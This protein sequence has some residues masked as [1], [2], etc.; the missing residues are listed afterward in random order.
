MSKKTQHF[1]NNI[2]VKGIV[3]N[4]SLGTAGYVLA[5]N[6]TSTYWAGGAGSGINAD[7]LDGYDS[8]AFALL[9][10]AN[11]TG[12]LSVSGNVVWHAGN[13]GAGSGLD[14]DLL[15][16]YNTTLIGAA[17]SIPVINSNGEIKWGAGVGSYNGGNPRNV[18]IGYSGGNYGALGYG[19]TFTSTSDLHNYGLNDVPTLIELYSGINVKSATSGTI[20]SPITW[21]DVFRARAVD[22]NALFKN[23][24][25]WDSGNDGSGSGLDADTLDGYDTTLTGGGSR[26]PVLLTG[27]GAWINNIGYNPEAD[28]YTGDGVVSPNYGMIA[29]NYTSF[30]GLGLGL[31]GYSG[32]KFATLGIERMRIDS[33]GDVGIGT[34][35]PTEKLQVEINTGING[36]EKGIALTNAS[37]SNLF[38][39][40]TGTGT[41]DKRALI[42]TGTATPLTFGTSYSEKMR[43]LNNGNFGIGAVPDSMLHVAGPNT[44]LRIGFGG[45]SQNYYDADNHYFRTGAA[46]TSMTINNSGSVAAVADFRAPIFYDSD[47]TSFYL[48]PNGSTSLNAAGNLLAA[49]NLVLGNGVDRYVRI[50]SSTNYLY[51]LKS[52][53]DDFQI[54]EAGTTP[55]FTIRYP[56][57]NVGIGTVVPSDKLVVSSNSGTVRSVIEQLDATGGTLAEFKATHGSGAS[58]RFTVGAGFAAFGLISSG[59]LVFLTGDVERA[60]FNSDGNF[61][62]NSNTVELGA[63]FRNLVIEDT[64]GAIVQTQ[65]GSG[66]VKAAMYAAG[67]AGYFG[68]RTNHST[69]FIVNNNVKATL[70]NAGY[71][72]IN[73]TSPQKYLHVT[74][75]DQ[76]ESRIRIQNT[77]I[78]GRA[79]DIVAG[80]HNTYQSGFSITDVTANLAR[81]V[82]DNNGNVGIGALAP[83]AALDIVGASSDTL[84]LRNGA[85]ANFYRIGRNTVTGELDFYGNQSGAYGYIFG[86]VDGE[87]MRIATNGNVAIGSPTPRGNLT[88]GT[89]AAGSVIE[90]SLHFGYTPAN[91]YGFR[92]VNQSNA[93]AT[94]AGLF[95][96]QRGTTA[97]WIDAVTISDQGDVGIGTSP[98]VKLHVESGAISEVVRLNSTGDTYIGLYNSGTIGAYLQSAA[99]AMYIWNSRNTPLLFGTNN[100]ERVRIAADGTFTHNGS[101][102]WDAGNDGSGSGLDADLLDGIQAVGLF[103]NMGANHGAF[104]DFNATPNFGSFFIQGTANGPATGSSQHYGI[105]LGIGADY[106]HSDYALQMAIGRYSDI[107]GPTTA[108]GARYLSVR[109]R[110][111]TTW[112]PWYKI[113]SGLSDKVGYTHPAQG[114]GG[115]NYVGY[116]PEG[117]SY[118]SGSASN[119]GAIR[120]L[121]PGGDATHKNAMISFTV[122]VYQYATGL[123]F[124]LHLAGYTY[125]AGARWLNCSASLVGDPSNNAEHTVRFGYDEASSRFCVYIGDVGTSWAYARIQVLDVGVNYTQEQSRLWIDG[126]NIDYVT[127]FSTV[128]VTKTN[129]TVG[130]YFN[131]QLI[132]NAGNDGSGSGL[133]AD[134]LDGY[135]LSLSQ[136]VNTVVARDGSGYVYLNY[137]N[138]NTANSENPSIGNIITTNGGDGFYRKSSP[139]HVISQ[140]A[141]VTD[142]NGSNITGPKYFI[143]NYNTGAGASPPLQA[144][145]NDNAQGAVMAFHRSGLYAVNMG[146]DS[147]NI[148]RIGGW[149]A[150]ANV[151]QLTMAGNAQFL[152]KV[153]ASGLGGFSATTFAVNSRNPIYRFDNADAF[154]LSYFQGTTS[155]IGTDTVGIHFGTATDAGCFFAVRNGSHTYSAGSFRSPIFYDSDNTAWFIDAAGTSQ[156]NILTLGGRG[157]DQ[158]VYYAGFTLDANTMPGNSTGFSY[159][160]NSPFTGP[161]ARFGEVNYSMQMA[162]PYGAPGNGLAFRSRNGDTGTF[163]S[164]FN[165]ALYDSTANASA[166]YATIYYDVNNTAY[167]TDPASTSVMNVIQFA[168]YGAQ[169]AANDQ[170]TYT[171]HKLVG[172][173]GGYYGFHLQGVTGAF[174]PVMWDAAGNGGSYVESS[175]LWTQYYSKANLCWGF[176]TSATNA[177]FDI[178]LPEGLYSGGRVDGSIFYDSNDTGYYCDPNGTS[179]LNVTKAYYHRR[180]THETGHLE[181]GYNNIG[182]SD[183]YTNPI[184]TIGSSYNPA[185]TTLSNMYGI[186]YSEATAASFNPSGATTW[187]MYVAAAGVCGIWLDGSGNIW[188]T[189]NITAYASDRRLKTNIKP[190][191]NA[192]D[193]LMRI[194]GV[195]FDWVDNIEEIGFKP[196]NMH[197]TGVIAQEIQEVIPDAVVLA[198]FNNHATELVGY[199]SEYLTVDKEKIIPLLIE[200]IKEQQLHI[201][202]LEEKIN[203][204]GINT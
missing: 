112:N 150:P 176:N 156:L 61:L 123:S 2:S 104:G 3:A 159:A 90:S 200:A 24:Q 166:L 14:A 48:D 172:A 41:S 127:S 109:N 92:I 78:T 93:S 152:G 165:V 148:F 5:S 179:N 88:I 56:S 27:G 16:G 58:G 173:K 146:L 42:A 20:G 32:M 157:T 45:A 30:G 133:D 13:D 142:S 175:G 197:E 97:A 199:D 158:A 102:I 110:E 98:A 36:F 72:G 134:L 113:A 107:E 12:S 55:R 115:Q 196:L 1:F 171:A 118:Y 50:G 40:V 6:G 122:R 137:I 106:P 151:M 170:T 103:N 139:A 178:Y 63:G 192:I 62:I 108:S 128:A 181:G 91:F 28:T 10:G 186:G 120:V 84:R 71:F 132:W 25:I 26:I 116:G 164:W 4:S 18:A 160:V 21:T 59:P 114:G 39:Y 35:N 162:M 145:S 167:Y 141:L 11:F 8:S 101:L 73:E 7:F 174:H 34:I 143:S 54:L 86:G 105:A 69:L 153:T 129:I 163:N 89:Q 15:D 77:G 161:I 64:S 80:V 99:G 95:K 100:T 195:E 76:T 60:R 131:N 126:W 111:A 53:G 147:D 38:L 65:T 29:G 43:L 82:I 144:Y 96:I 57:G 9:A 66:A 31:S 52:V 51:D 81:F 184:F 49:G 188:A 70:T 204:M 87:R 194:S 177:A 187:G 47:N 201:N 155:A 202:R 124:D 79:W 185:A 140:L 168:A 203:N 67:S 189:G 190:I 191:T 75:A 198:P 37:D 19:V 154:G 44:G 149:S 74:S 22:S 193:K 117:G 68:T 94:A 121:L 23:R 33:A 85:G 125:D 136:A 180:Y 169:I 119:T 46:V 182:A 83:D 183:S 130:K 138:S 135:N 17:S